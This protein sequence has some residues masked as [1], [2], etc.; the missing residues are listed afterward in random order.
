MSTYPHT[1]LFTQVDRTK[2]PDFFVRFMDE[3]QNPQASRRASG[4]CW[5]GWP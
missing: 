2:D 3:A 1:G 5:S 4:S